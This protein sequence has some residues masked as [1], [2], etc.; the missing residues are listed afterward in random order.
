M[1]KKK[2]KPAVAKKVTAR[3]VNVRDLA[4]GKGDVTGGG[5]G[6]GGFSVKKT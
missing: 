5:S 4:F 6:F 2:G 3:K 1:A